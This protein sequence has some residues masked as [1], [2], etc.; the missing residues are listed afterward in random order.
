MSF[1][2]ASRD[3]VYIPDGIS[4]RTYKDTKGTQ[5]DGSEGSRKASLPKYQPPE[6]NFRRTSHVERMYHEP[7]RLSK[8][9]IELSD[10]LS[11][12]HAT[13]GERESNRKIRLGYSRQDDGSVASKGKIGGEGSS[14][15]NEDM[16]RE[17]RTQARKGYAFAKQSQ[18]A[19]Y[20]RRGGLWGSSWQCRG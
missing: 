6:K 5:E 7:L 17:A 14:L 4:V 12:K 10:T 16:A 9:T 3:T 20:S 19:G 2:R 11:E 8:D 1:G 13:P 18:H 15:L